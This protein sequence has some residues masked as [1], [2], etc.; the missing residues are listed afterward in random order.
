MEKHLSNAQVDRLGERLRRGAFDE[1]DRRTL[2]EYKLTF[3]PAYNRVVERVYR[4]TR[5]P[6]SGRP[7]KLTSSIGEKLKRESI[8]LSQM[9]D[10]AG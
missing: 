7:S 3:E 10:I 1:A 2:D 8:R 5:L 6:L 4:V 9:Q